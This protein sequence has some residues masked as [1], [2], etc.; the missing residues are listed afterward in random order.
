[1]IGGLSFF[2]VI[3]GAITSA[4]VARAQATQAASGGDP[5]MLKLSELETQL[6]AIKADLAQRPGAPGEQR[7]PPS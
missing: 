2:A 1:M 4:F 3:T 7:G 6:A 5:V